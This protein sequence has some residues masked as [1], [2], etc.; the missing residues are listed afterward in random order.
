[1]MGEKAE[2]VV[3]QIT[4]RPLRAADGDTEA[5]D[6]TATRHNQQLRTLEK[7]LIPEAISSRVQ[8]SGEA[9]E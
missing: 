1:M 4:A 5:E 6:K 2:K 8:R 7:S 9:N 3:A